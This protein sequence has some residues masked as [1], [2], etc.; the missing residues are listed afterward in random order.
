MNHHQATALLEAVGKLIKAKGRFHT[1]QNY[2]ELVK[3]YDTASI[4]LSATPAPAGWKSMPPEATEAMMHAAEDVPAPRPYGAVYR[5]MFA[6]APATQEAP[7]DTSMPVDMS[8]A[9][10]WIT[11]LRARIDSLLAII[12]AAPGIAPQGA[13]A[14]PVRYEQRMIAPAGQLGS[15]SETNREMYDRYSANPDI[16]DGFSYEVRALF[17]QQA[18]AEGKDG[19]RLDWADPERPNSDCGYDHVTAQTPFGRILITWKSWKE[20][21]SPTVDEHPVEGYFYAGNDVDDA[22][23][24]AELAYFA[25]IEA[26]RAST[27]KGGDP[28]QTGTLNYGS[29][30]NA[31]HL[32]TE[33]PGQA[34]MTDKLLTIIACAY[35][36]VGAHDAPAHILGVL[37]NPQAATDEQVDAMLPYQLV[38]AVP[39]GSA[40]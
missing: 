22:K 9:K 23:R 7:D 4:E 26:A 37:A 32:A 1:E 33:K 15:W 19:E 8:Q 31:S 17:A 36:I 40:K 2:A 10:R 30:I 21:E 24:N 34:A 28:A 12:N 6:A 39:D 35:Q 5:A 27:D 20:Y 25:A 13:Q 29:S 14:Q 11:Q 3:A 38:E 18:G 16:G